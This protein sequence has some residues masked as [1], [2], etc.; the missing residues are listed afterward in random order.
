MLRRLGLSRRRPHVRPHGWMQMLPKPPEGSRTPGSLQ[1]AYLNAW[2]DR[3]ECARAAGREKGGRSEEKEKKRAAAAGEGRNTTGR[4]RL[5]HDRVDGDDD[6]GD[7]E[8]KE[9]EGGTGGDDGRNRKC[10]AA[11]AADVENEPETVRALLRSAREAA[12]REAEFANR[13]AV[14]RAAR[15]RAWFQPTLDFETAYFACVLVLLLF[16]FSVLF[17]LY[18]S[19][20]SDSVFVY[21][22]L[23]ARILGAF[24]AI[25][26]FY[27]LLRAAA[28]RETANVVTQIN[29]DF[30]GVT[31]YL[32]QTWP[33]T[34]RLLRELYPYNAV[35]RRIVPPV[36][37]DRN[38]AHFAEQIIYQLIFDLIDTAIRLQP[39]QPEGRVREWRGWWH[40]SPLLR[41]AWANSRGTVGLEPAA[42]V[43]QCLMPGSVPPAPSVW[44]KLTRD[45]SMFVA[46]VVLLLTI[47]YVALYWLWAATRGSGDGGDA[48]TLEYTELFFEC[49]AEF[50]VSAA[51]VA[52][53]LESQ[54]QVDDITFD[55]R[56]PALD[57]SQQS[58][59][60][61]YPNS[62]PI[63][64]GI[65]SCNRMLQTKVRVPRDVDP[66]LVA[67]FAFTTCQTIFRFISDSLELADPPDPANLRN[68]R[69]YF[70]DPL[71][72][73]QWCEQ[74]SAFVGLKGRFIQEEIYDK[75]E[76]SEFYI[77]PQYAR[78]GR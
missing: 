5:L 31:L 13:E 75:A 62:V 63:Y 36:D 30:Q 70:R 58:V 78:I 8:N 7:K 22:A 18:H 39:L 51:L 54:T 28:E 3:I 49:L 60:L 71:L 1:D 42:F 12:Q 16:A 56:H 68:W 2:S 19:V 24:F 59:L 64:L 44:A 35:I 4:A 9:E 46:G 34:D 66:D 57:F 26:A 11:E 23:Y 15:T 73:Q 41:E 14:R 55:I 72:R 74:R 45:P 47:V 53:V 76:C 21:V 40:T 69:E 50:Y 27:Y 43:D 20:F 48:T 37:L 25:V 65:H 6:E 77:P 52:L 17:F 67:L 33:F 61:A 10:E 32:Y 38:L 29:T